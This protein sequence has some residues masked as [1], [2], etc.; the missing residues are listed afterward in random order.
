VMIR[1]AVATTLQSAPQVVA[2]PVTTTALYLNLE[3]ASCCRLCSDNYLIYSQ[4]R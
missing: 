3:T 4:G 1:S 2:H